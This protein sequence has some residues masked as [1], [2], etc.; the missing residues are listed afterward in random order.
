MVKK[1]S[2]EQRRDA[3]R[4]R[5]SSVKPGVLPRGL[6]G[7]NLRHYKLLQNVEQG[8]ADGIHEFLV[9]VAAFLDKFVGI[10]TCYLCDGVKHDFWKSGRAL[11]LLLA[12]QGQAIDC[13][14]RQI[15]MVLTE[16]WNVLV[17][18]QLCRI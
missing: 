7:P 12:I 13:H 10:I 6:S 9:I 17:T 14:M 18:H 1:Y 3:L 15:K 2:W 5:V 16:L 8:S 11:F 4:V